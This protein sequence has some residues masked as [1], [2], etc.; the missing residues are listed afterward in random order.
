MTDFKVFDNACRA[1]GV[2]ERLDIENYPDVP[3][4]HIYGRTSA[5]ASQLIQ[6]AHEHIPALPSVHF[7]FLDSKNV[8]AV[9]F[10]HGDQYFI[11]VTSGAVIMLHLVL[12][13]MLANPAVLTW[14]GETNRERNDIRSLPP[15]VIDPERLFHMGVRPVLAQDVNRVRYSKH[16]GD[17]ALM[18]LLGHEIAHVTR[19]HVDYLNAKHPGAFL[20]KVGWGGSG[21]ESLERQCIEADADRRSVFARS[22]SMYMSFESNE[23]NKPPW[24]KRRATA[25]DY[26]FDWAFSVNVLFRLFGDE[27]FAPADLVSSGYPPLPLRRRMAMEYACRVLMY[28]VGDKFDGSIKDTIVGSM[29]SCEESFTA[30]GAEPAKGGIESAFSDEST[31]HFHR[32]NGLWAS[33]RAELQEYSYESL[34]DVCG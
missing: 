3:A 26:Q 2:G 12:D 25:A 31:N 32:L 27:K 19:G 5:V 20:G 7:A 1:V 18:F 11:G 24:L 34:D 8:N 9:A 33:M 28:H 16:L 30:I 10:K 17:Q 14:V 13:R 22:N 4:F 6:S 29:A 15:G 21:D 23:S